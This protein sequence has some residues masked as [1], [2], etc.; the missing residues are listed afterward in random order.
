MSWKI[1]MW[2]QKTK[3]LPNPTTMSK[4]YGE[5]TPTHAI[6]WCSTPKVVETTISGGSLSTKLSCHKYFR[7][8][9]YL[10]F[11]TRTSITADSINCN[12]MINGFEYPEAIHRNA[13]LC[14]MRT[15]MCWWINDIIEHWSHHSERSRNIHQWLPST[16]DIRDHSIQTKTQP[17]IHLE[18]P[19]KIKW[20]ER[21]A[22]GVLE[23]TTLQQSSSF[24]SW[25]SSN[26]IWNVQ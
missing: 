3:Y 11:P 15:M 22:R 18:T 13:H 20:V 17:D 21:I 19:G 5:L 24:R 23:R 1:R 2:R 10:T 12:A 4:G 26:S 8:V 9:R 25:K 16:D 6:Q 7:H 14:T